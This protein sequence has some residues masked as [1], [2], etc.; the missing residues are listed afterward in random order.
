MCKYCIIS[1]QGLATNIHGYR[2]DSIQKLASEKW[3]HYL[4][5]SGA[6]IFQTV[7][8]TERTSLYLECLSSWLITFLLKLWMPNQLCLP[9][10]HN[11]TAGPSGRLL[12]STKC[13]NKDCPNPKTTN[14][15]LK[16]ISST[17][18]YCLF[19]VSFH[20]CGVVNSGGSLYINSWNF[21]K[22]KNSNNLNPWYFFINQQDLA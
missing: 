21:K 11:V 10:L 15:I 3:E 5:L 6:E 8:K 18:K 13:F 22:L 19:Y 7:L 9:Q 2:Y 1:F 12:E 14:I 16:Y 20:Y 17:G 4:P